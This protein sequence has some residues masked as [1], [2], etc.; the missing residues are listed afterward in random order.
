[1][2]SVNSLP[3]LGR[4]VEIVVAFDTKGLSPESY[5]V[6]FE[7]QSPKGGRVCDAVASFV[8]EE[9]LSS[10]DLLGFEL[11][12]TSSGNGADTFLQPGGEN[13]H[14]GKPYLATKPAGGK[15]SPAEQHIY[16]RFDLKSVKDA[17]KPI[18][19]AILLLSVA[20][21]GHRST[22]TLNIYAVPRGFTESWQEVG[23]EAL[24]WDNSPSASGIES[25]PFLGQVEM[26][27]S[28]GS[29]ESRDDA[30][31]LHSTALDDYL[32]QA[33]DTVTIVLVRKSSGEKETRFHSREGNVQRSP[34]L[35]IR[36]K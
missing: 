21:D 30:I 8:I 12:R 11:I 34:A 17:G 14:G 26:D 27:N 19:R 23:D 10:I 16:V 32:R 13:S 3:A 7:L 33:D 24:S 9:N 18:D 15:A 22:S 20:G 1:M 6:I 29:L 28:G 31:R 25:L 4:S 5:E 2:L 36:L 35:A